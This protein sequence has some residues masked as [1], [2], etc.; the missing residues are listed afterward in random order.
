[1]MRQKQRGNQRAIE[2]QNEENSLP[3]EENF[4]SLEI[5]ACDYSI[6]SELMRYKIKELRE[7]W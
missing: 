4:I 3:L 1:M 6:F 5:N 2:K 7:A